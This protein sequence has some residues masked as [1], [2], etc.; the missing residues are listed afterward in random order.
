AT[1]RSPHASRG[2]NP[3]TPVR[4]SVPSAPEKDTAIPSLTVTYSPPVTSHL[5]EQNRSFVLTTSRSRRG[6]SVAPACESWHSKVCRLGVKGSGIRSAVR[7]MKI[8]SVARALPPYQ[9]TQQEIFEA[10]ARHWRDRLD[11]PELL[12]RFH[13]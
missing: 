12:A 1:R 5:Q 4:R 3:A 6:A 13:H 2:P 11:N 7:F 8:V 10:L 9:F